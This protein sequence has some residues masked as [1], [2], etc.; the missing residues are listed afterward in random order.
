[1][2]FDSYYQGWARDKTGQSRDFFV[3]VP[4]VSRDNHAG[5]SR[6]N[7]SQSRLSRG[8]LSRGIL[9]A[10]L[11]RRFLSRSRLSR[12]FESGLRDGTGIPTLSR[13]NRPSLPII[14]TM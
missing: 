5:Q 3:P 13:D 2:Q 4:Q 10:E 7:L 8:L 1:M 14:I 12:G 11:S 9:V 6:K